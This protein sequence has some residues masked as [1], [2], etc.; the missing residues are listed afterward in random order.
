MRFLGLPIHY[1]HKSMFRAI[2]RVIEKVFRIGY[3]TESTKRGKFARLTVGIGMTKPLISK[4]MLDGCLQRVEY[5]GLPTICFDC[6]VYKS[7]K[8]QCKKNVEIEIEVGNSGNTDPKEQDNVVVLDK[9]YSLS[10]QV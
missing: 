7:F 10:M 6:V 5:E 4:F 8:G 3:N 9:N 2:S 1:Y